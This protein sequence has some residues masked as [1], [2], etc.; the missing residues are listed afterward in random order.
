M[1]VAPAVIGIG[2]HHTEW[3]FDGTELF[4]ASL[5]G[6]PGIAPSVSPD[7]Q[8]VHYL[9]EASGNVIRLGRPGH[10]GSESLGVVATL[11]AGTYDFSQAQTATTPTHI[12]VLVEKQVSG[13][14]RLYLHRYT[15]DGTEETDSP[16]LI[17]AT[18]VAGQPDRWGVD[19]DAVTGRSWLMVARSGGDIIGDGLYEIFETGALL[20][21]SFD[22]PFAVANYDIRS[23]LQVAGGAAFVGWSSLVETQEGLWRFGIGAYEADLSND[24]S[25][26]H[27]ETPSIS[28]M[29]NF[30]VA[31]D[32]N[33]VF[34]SGL[35]GS[36][37]LERIWPFRWT[38]D[39]LDPAWVS[40]HTE[41]KWLVVWG[42]AEVEAWTPPP[43]L[44]RYPRDD[45]RAGPASAKAV[46]PPS[47]FR[48]DG[49]RRDTS[50][51]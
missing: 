46:W 35:S 43:P 45:G 14:W 17:R 47:G 41:L 12:Y 22:F 42:Y 30:A 10:D 39:V 27:T 26:A 28:T 1:A 21:D 20:S 5:G 38:D 13:T 15:W 32:A 49:L 25:Y 48:Q 36:T 6:T 40:P 31:E 3:D 34:Y 18:R 8:W 23:H 33:H 9:H 50:N 7:G 16:S 24:G 37:Q 19:Y 11:P 29:E 44:V 2:T 4:R 51:H